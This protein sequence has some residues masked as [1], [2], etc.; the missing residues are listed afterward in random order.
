MDRKEWQKQYQKK[1]YE[2]NKEY[3]KKLS[4]QQLKERKEWFRNLVSKLSCI[5][6]GENHPGCLDF[7]HRDPAQKENEVTVMVVNKCSRERILKEIS[8]CDVLCAN[9]HRKYH[10]EQ[11]TVSMKGDVQ[12][13]Q[14]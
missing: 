3:R 1:R 6:C 9:C 12:V 5:K 4:D 11:R 2:E 13:F 10:Y 14:T 7:H 8:K